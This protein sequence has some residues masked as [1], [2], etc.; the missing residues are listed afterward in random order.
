M[1][2][3]FI[4]LY[5]YVLYV[6]YTHFEPLALE[7]SDGPLQFMLLINALSHA[8][9]S[10]DIY[11]LHTTSKIIST[12]FAIILS[13]TEKHVIR[14]FIRQTKNV[15]FNDKKSSYH[16][17]CI[18]LLSIWERLLFVLVMEMNEIFVY[19]FYIHVTITTTFQ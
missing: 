4:S 5:V 11:N 10:F 17:N 12:F 15:L 3:A 9:F 6:Y 13:S 7:S 14:F 18:D 2:A 8:L 19:T 1:H 16:C